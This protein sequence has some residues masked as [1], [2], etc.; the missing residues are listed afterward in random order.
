[1]WVLFT[2]LTSFFNAAYFLLNQK[3][4]MSAAL[5]MVYR[6]WAVFF[7]LLPFAFFFEPIKN[8]EFYA[9]CVVQGALVAYADGRFFATLRRFGAEV[10]TS[11]QPFSIG[12]TFVLWLVIAPSTI[13]VYLQKPM[14]AL[15]IVFALAGIVVS[16]RLFNKSKVS[17][18]ALKF[19]ISALVVG[20]ICD[21]VNKKA[22]GYGQGDVV[23][24]SYFYVLLIA[25]VAGVINLIVYLRQ[26]GTLKQVVAKQNLKYLPV[27]LLLM[28]CN[29]SK[30]FAMYYAFN[31][32]YVAALL[33]IY[34]LWIAGYNWIRAKMVPDMVYNRMN[35]KA[36][37][38]LLCSVVVLI[39]AAD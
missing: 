4:A 15:F 8:W 35:V 24:V 38:L 5:F 33:Y 18:Q 9:L 3:M 12:I 25:L 32:S 22:M 37:A 11:L 13:F 17:M 28:G 23:S 39:L 34:I 19:V 2:L 29:V 1:M 27:F 6:G 30:N 16:V 20:A 10:A 31:P 21:I 14:E 26:D 36:A 7:M